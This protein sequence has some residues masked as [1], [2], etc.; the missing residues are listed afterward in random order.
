VTLKPEFAVT[1]SRIL[2]SINRHRPELTQGYKH[3]FIVAGVSSLQ[4]NGGLA[5]IGSKTTTSLSAKPLNW[6]SPKSCKAMIFRR[7][8]FCYYPI[9]FV[10]T[11]I[12]NRVI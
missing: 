2:D 7:L 8:L 9:L 6:A 3:C 5:G 11:Q 12:S 4:K 1:I 10:V